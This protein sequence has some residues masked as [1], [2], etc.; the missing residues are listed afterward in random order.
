MIAE[1]INDRDCLLPTT[2]YVVGQL[3]R[4]DLQKLARKFSN[5][6]K[7]AAWIRSLPQLDDTGHNHGMPTIACDTPQRARLPTGTPNCYERVLLYLALAELIDPVPIRQMATR[8]TP[9]GRHT[10]AVEDGT[11]VNLN[12]SRR[13][14][15]GE[16]PDGD[17][18]NASLHQLAD[19]R[20]RDR[21]HAPRPGEPEPQLPDRLPERQRHRP[22]EWVR[23]LAW[24]VR[25]AECHADVIDEH[26]GR[27]RMRRV[28]G[29]FAR[30]GVVPRPH[31][32]PPAPDQSDFDLS[33]VAANVGAQHYG[34]NGKWAATLYHRALDKMG[35]V[36]RWHALDKEQ[37]RE[38]PHHDT[39]PTPPHQEPPP[40]GPRAPAPPGDGDQSLAER[41]DSDGL[42]LD[43]DERAFGE[44]MA[45]L[46]DFTEVDSWDPYRNLVELSHLAEPDWRNCG[47]GMPR[48]AVELEDL[49]RNFDWKSL[50]QDTL[51]V[52]HGIGGGILKTYGL[53][54]VS[55]SLGN[56]YEKQGWVKPSGNRP[57]GGGGGG[58]GG[59][60]G[61]GAR[62]WQGVQAGSAQLEQQAAAERE[63]LAR[64]Q[65]TRERQAAERITAERQRLI[66]ERAQREAERAR[67]AAEQHEAERAEQD[68]E[69][70][71]NDAEAPRPLVGSLAAV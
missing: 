48:N 71:E 60:A 50:G 51:G 57:A 6:R 47:C 46:H 42:E 14:E 29:F 38:Q 44:G 21:P 62:V 22:P 66:R 54:G 63:R 12:P 19:E 43:D 2:Y 13:V 27:E 3:G 36:G 68:E 1:P 31:G 52:V 11:E 53:G 41:N 9:A 20:E 58:G 45:T 25:I 59:R 24:C 70:T 5:T 67:L 65:A 55:D 61:G 39:Q 18:R 69:E 64:E 34:T 49:R 32:H 17:H 26:N 23:V 4:D 8:N 40:R 30:H 7:L 56:V 16:P 10:V 33:V 15:S 35:L 28:R 37:P